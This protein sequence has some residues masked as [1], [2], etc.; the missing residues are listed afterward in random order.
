MPPRPVLPFPG[1]ALEAICKALGETVTGREIPNLI[2]PLRVEEDVGI[3]S[4]TKWKRLYNAV[5]EAQNRQQDGRP[6]IRLI[7][8]V[9]APVRFDTAHSHEEARAA[10]NKPLAH[11]GFK[12]NE[13]GIVV[14]GKTA[15]SVA[16]AQERADSLR[17]ELGRRAVHADVL[18][19]C[20]TELLQQNYFHA[21]LEASKS[22]AQ[23][24]RDRT[25]LTSDGS[26]LADAA[27]S[28][29][30]DPVPLA[31]N[32]L[33]TSTE[34]SEHTGLAQF[35]RA[36]FST[37]RNPT[38][39]APKVHWAMDR[40]EALDLLTLASMLHRRLDRALTGIRSPK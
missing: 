16:E 23:K 40:Q 18:A 29:R 13:H 36:L 32:S 21:V 39:H 27:F 37:A 1:S 22:V 11:Y 35:T 31:F 3:E 15:G 6:V 10:V 20:R 12:V 38:A 4:G 24:I 19:F 9:M 17:A 25:G 33:T 28:L 34:R 5:V 8:E 14:R 2:A 7:R 26:D 30:A